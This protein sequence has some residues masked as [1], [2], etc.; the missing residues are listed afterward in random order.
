MPA[1]DLLDL[2]S[3]DDPDLALTPDQ[4]LRGVARLFA[5]GLERLRQREPELTDPIAILLTQNPSKF[6][7]SDLELL[8][9]RSVTVHTG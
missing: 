8:P 7:T 2:I 9:R 3:I 4:R 1:A 5:L 6:H